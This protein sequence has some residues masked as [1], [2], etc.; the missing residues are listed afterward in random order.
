MQHFI[1]R[2]AMNIDGLGDE[3]INTFYNRGFIRHISDL[4]DPAKT[5]LMS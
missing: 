1:G 2:K 4:Y 5:I 3:T